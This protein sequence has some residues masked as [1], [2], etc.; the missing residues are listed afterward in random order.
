LFGLELELDAEFC[1][2]NQRLLTTNEIEGHGWAQRIPLADL[3]ESA[4][5]DAYEE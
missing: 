1:A 4:H 5:A 3:K 2:V